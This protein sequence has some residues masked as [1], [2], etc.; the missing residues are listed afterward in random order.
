MGQNLGAQAIGCLLHPGNVVRECAAERPVVRDHV[1]M[2][3]VEASHA[4]LTGADTLDPV[5]QDLVR[6]AVREHGGRVRRALGRELPAEIGAHAN[7]LG[8]ML[9]RLCEGRIAAHNVGVDR[10]E[11]QRRIR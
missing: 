1:S 2:D 8:L 6:I 9:Y 3:D 11:A 7:D 5:G 10:V 4:T